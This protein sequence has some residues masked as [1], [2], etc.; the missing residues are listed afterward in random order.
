MGQEVKD[1]L[2][3]PRFLWRAHA[4]NQENAYTEPPA[5]YTTGGETVT[6]GMAA[7]ME[8]RVPLGCQGVSGMPLPC[9][10]DVHHGG[11]GEISRTRRERHV[12][13][14]LGKWWTIENCT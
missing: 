1:F 8:V 10:A 7:G 13:I 4:T 6:G 3:G 5:V 12:G 14:A 9:L 11:H 2:G